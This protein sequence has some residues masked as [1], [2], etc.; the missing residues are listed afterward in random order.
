M[1]AHDWNTCLIL[2]QCFTTKP[3]LTLNSQ[4]SCIVLSCDGITILPLSLKIESQA[5]VVWRSL[6]KPH[7]MPGVVTHNALLSDLER[8]NTSIIWCQNWKQFIPILNILLPPGRLKKSSF[9][10]KE[11]SSW[12]QVLQNSQKQM[13]EKIPPPVRKTHSISWGWGRTWP[14]DGEDVSFGGEAPA[15]ITHTKIPIS[16]LTIS[17]VNRNCLFISRPPRPE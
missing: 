9:G 15:D 1:L 3:R 4:C 17:F 16:E 14:L 2:K 12:C 13:E 11:G 7:F 10:S 5:L 6:E 8:G